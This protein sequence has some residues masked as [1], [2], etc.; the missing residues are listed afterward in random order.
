MVMLVALLASVAGAALGTWVAQPDAGRRERPRLRIVLVGDSTV[1]DESG[2]GLGFRRLVAARAE[3]VNEAASGRSSKSYLAEGRWQRALAL[4]GDY[5]LI[6]F[7]HNDQPGKG[8]ERETDPET[9]FR[10]NL[11]RY[12]D[13]ARA[14]GGRP[15]LVTSLTRR[16]YRPDGSIATTLTPYAEATKAVAAEKKTPV[17]D[18][19][20]ISMAHAA[21]AGDGAWATLSPRDPRGEID[22]THLNEAGSTVVGAMVADAIRASVPELAPLLRGQP[23]AAT[24]SPRE[25]V[26]WYRTPAA[27]WN[28]ALP[29]G[30]G[31]LGAMVFGGVAEERLQLNEDSVWAG[32]K[33]DR[34]NP[35]AAK[36][37]PE[38]RRLLFEGRVAEAEKLADKAVVSQPRRMPPYQTLGDLVLTFDVPAD[39]SEYRRELDI[40]TARAR[41]SFRAG[42]VRFTREVFATAVDQV[43]VVRLTADAPGRISFSAT[44]RRESDATVRTHGPA[45]VVLEGR[46]LPPKTERQAAEPR[47]GT[48]FTGMVRAVADGGAVRAAGDA[49][50]VERADAV[51]LFVAAA[52]SYRER[53]PF[54]ACLQ[55]IEAASSR[56]ADRVDAE[57]L[58]DYQRLFRR[59]A[60]QLPSAGDAASLSTPE[61]LARVKGG[62]QD[63]GLEQLHFQF[64]RYLLI[65]S[66]RPGDLAANLQGIWNDS[67][68]PSWDSKY[69]V[70][71]NTEMNYWPAEVTNLSEM[72]D[73]LFDL[74][75][76]ARPNGRQVAKNM[77][78]ARG[79]VIH[80]NTDA[81]GHASPID[82]VRSGI[83]P[84]GGA[85]LSL[86]FWDRYDFTRDRE[87][88]RSR[89]YPV[90]KEA[91]E[92]Y[93]DYL[94]EDAQGRLLSG[95]ST[96]PENEYV[97][98]DGTKGAL[99]MGP[100]M[101]TQIAYALFTRVLAAAEILGT[102][103]EFRARVRAA[104]A[105]LPP[106]KIGRHGRLQE[107]LEDYDDAS[108]GHRH[109]SHLFALHPDDQITPGRTP[110]L[111]RAAR[112]TLERR[113]AA[114]SG[115]TGW[116]RA[117]IILFWARLLEADL[118]HENLVALLA[119]STMPNLFDDHPPF[120]IDGNFGATAGVAEMLLQSHSGELALLPA[121]PSAWRT[122]SIRGLRG[123]GAIEVDL[124]WEAGSATAV[125]LRPDLDG[126][127][128][129]RPP[130]GQR[131]AEIT[132]DSAAVTVQQQ[133]DDTVRVSLAAGRE[134][135]LRLERR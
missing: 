12:V 72:H 16:H 42:G 131:I 115:H 46:A 18:L 24:E 51:T 6:Q 108:P 133:A 112:I 84:S 85:W 66:S 114:G 104:R 40:D 109:I 80:H 23:P 50:V 105:K 127:H 17:I 81:W 70:N 76:N 83:W 61:R 25:S 19:H 34:T 9:T 55:T 2:W 77:Y 100:Y 125:R 130:R 20:A 65:S 95:P 93:L 113:L 120:Q 38:I 53:D 67:L 82:S 69:T 73:A 56:P 58:H 43:I 47:T 116:S 7:G 54:A 107:W 10:A 11:R 75:D 1:T 79:F 124:E 126:V 134:Y 123:R 22:R 129:I 118:A 15:I 97:T 48:A 99:T 86:H 31:R 36:A 78:G 101:D 90:M 37:I 14:A 87:F 3:V 102:D 13:E 33:M 121:L 45:T 62:A 106:M 59:V 52:T 117:W 74:V 32:Q 49:V 4:R 64:G 41:V 57:H 39:A 29:I 30:N 44:L 27:T 91:A 28:E 35:A 68:A 21:R 92:F 60:L 89:G 63:A 8:P 135:A 128:V 71:I 110:D 26:L 122:G 5:Y 94:T 88:L 111:A 96:S 98:P 132:S 103:D 119:K